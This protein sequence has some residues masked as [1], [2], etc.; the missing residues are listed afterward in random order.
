MSML[1]HYGMLYVHQS[2]FFCNASSSVV[3]LQWPHLYQNS[4]SLG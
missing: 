4:W 3:L 2:Q 1:V